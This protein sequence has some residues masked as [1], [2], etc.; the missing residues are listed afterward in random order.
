MVIIN[1]P[2]QESDNLTFSMKLHMIALL[3]KKLVPEIN[4]APLYCCYA[5]TLSKKT[6]HKSLN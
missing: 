1:Q 2:K 4:Y 6:A 3:Y 5:F